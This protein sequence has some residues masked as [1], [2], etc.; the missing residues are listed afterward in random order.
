MIAMNPMI[1]ER[2]R[3]RVSELIEIE[4]YVRVCGAILEHLV[5]PNISTDPTAAAM[6]TRELSRSEFRD[7]GNANGHSE[8]SL[9]RET[10]AK[11]LVR[12][13]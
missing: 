8:P 10:P 2:Q 4:A 5:Q 9:A 13:D 3:E 1:R 7:V 11:R 6:N 12:D